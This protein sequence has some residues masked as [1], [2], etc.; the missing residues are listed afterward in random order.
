MTRHALRPELG[1]GTIEAT[2]LTNG[3]QLLRYD[4]QFTQ[5]HRVNYSFTEERFELEVCF[6]GKMRISELQAG[7]GELGGNAVSFTP[8]RSTSG[9]IVHPGGERYRAVSLA[10]NLDG[11]SPYLGSIDPKFFAQAVS[12][13]SSS[14]GNDLYLGSQKHLRGL[15]AIFT[16]MFKL[17]AETP[18]KTLMLEARVMAALAL[19]IEASENTDSDG[20]EKEQLALAQHE[21]DAL[22]SLPDV[23]W[24]LRHHA[25]TVRNLSKIISMSPKRLNYGFKILF[26][27]T[28]MEY[29]RQQCLNRACS[30][31]LETNHTVE[32]IAFEL[33][34]ATASNFVYAFRKRRGCTPA[35]YRRDLS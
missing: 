16:E 7:Q 26:G 5:D 28:P 4:V 11:L 25:P 33:G 12:R 8:Q 35:Q 21:V 18:G 29:H 9:E 19:L 34:Y 3:L 6:E 22:R 2:S 13:L 14:Y 23:M 1:R 15:P 10:G 32:H 24:S 31:L 27:V 17:R 20:P 30:L